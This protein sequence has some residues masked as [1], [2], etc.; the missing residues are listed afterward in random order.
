M[1]EQDAR[2]IAEE[3][4]R[5]INDLLDLDVKI[6]SAV[7]LSNLWMFTTIGRGSEPDQPQH[8]RGI[9]VHA[10]GRVNTSLTVMR[11]DEQLARFRASLATTDDVRWL[12]PR[13][14]GDFDRVNAV[15]ARGYPAVLPIL[16][17]LLDWLRD[18]NWPIAAKLSEFVASIGAPLA[19]HLR[20]IF[21]GDDHGWKYW[22]MGDVIGCN[23][24]LFDIFKD[25]LERIAAD[26]TPEERREELDE[27]ARDVLE[28]PPHFQ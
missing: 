11:S 3:E 19:P 27:R 17:D 23:A 25:E 26:P 24:A 5:R 22:L 14:K 16:P 13:S 12:I 20:V 10:D 18:G 8:L 28:N 6:E 21:D 1:T 4:L 9:A 15:I 7:C 2:R